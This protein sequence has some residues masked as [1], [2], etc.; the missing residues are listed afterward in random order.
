MPRYVALFRGINVGKA[1]RIA[2]ADLR[3]LLGKLGYTGI[4]TLLNSGNAVYTGAAEPA[5]THAER[6]RQAVLKKTGV[7]AL[8]IVK[9]AKDMAAIIAGNEIGVIADD[10]SRLLVA[11]TNESKA[12]AAVKALARVEWGAERLHI[13]KH[14]A[15]LWCANGILESMALGP[16]LKGLNGTGTTRNWATLNKIHALMGKSD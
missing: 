10:P 9:S 15:Y 14:A 1:K 2:M 5:D 16:L 11:L 4:A 8:V 3:T 7:D 13:G 6:I 12:L